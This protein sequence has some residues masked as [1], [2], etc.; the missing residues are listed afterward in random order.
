M[1]TKERTNQN[2]KDELKLR[3][4]N[5]NPQLSLKVSNLNAPNDLQ[6]KPRA[7]ASEVQMTYN[8]EQK[9]RPSRELE[10]WPSRQAF[11][12]FSLTFR[13]SNNGPSASLLSAGSCA[14]CLLG[15]QLTQKYREENFQKLSSNSAKLTKYRA[16]T[17]RTQA[18]RRMSERILAGI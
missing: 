8:S 3:R 17:D 2:H 5:W 11:P 6:E 9:C 15:T 7:F 4:T 14:K 1:W 16:A 13:M 18:G 10:S 12:L